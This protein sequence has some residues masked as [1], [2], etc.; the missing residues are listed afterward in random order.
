MYAC[1]LINFSY[2]HKAKYRQFFI[3]PIAAI[4]VTPLSKPLILSNVVYTNL[5]FAQHS[6]TK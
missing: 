4:F 2:F 5:I 1:K 6:W 3:P